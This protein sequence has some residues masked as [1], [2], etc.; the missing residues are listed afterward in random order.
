MEEEPETTTITTKWDGYYPAPSPLKQLLILVAIGLIVPVLLILYHAL[1]LLDDFFNGMKPVAGPLGLCTGLALIAFLPLLLWYMHGRFKADIKRRNIEARR[2]SANGY[3][4]YDAYF[5]TREMFVIPK[6]T[7]VPPVPASLTY[8]PRITIDSNNK[9]SA[10]A[11]EAPVPEI[12]V[13]KPQVSELAAKVERNSLQ[14]CLG[15][16]LTTGDYLIAELPKK[17]IKI[18]GAYSARKE[19]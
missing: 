5:D 10:N 15:K 18:I 11:I 3:G 9:S 6:P 17:H 1:P 16:S 19:L 12:N 2:F 14:I 7:V 8:A 13:A 4:I